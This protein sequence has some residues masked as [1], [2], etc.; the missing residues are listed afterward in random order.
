MPCSSMFVNPTGTV[1][2][3][4]ITCGVKLGSLSLTSVTFMMTGTSAVIA[5]FPL[6]DAT[7]VN[8]YAFWA[9]RLSDPMR[10]SDPDWMEPS[11]F[12]C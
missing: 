7:T 3:M 5:G 6:S 10:Y 1:S 2:S 9:S 11:G 8:T 12:E 4:W